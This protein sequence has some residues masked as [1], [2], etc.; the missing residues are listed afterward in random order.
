MDARYYNLATDGPPV[1]SS[2]DAV[3]L[4]AEASGQRAEIVV[5]PVER[6][7]DDF[8]RLSTGIAG[9]VIQKFLTYRL[10]VVILGDISM[11]LQD[12]SSL[13]DFVYECNSG[14]HV[15]FVSGM[16]ELNRRLQPQGN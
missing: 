11:H 8:F 7:S 10:R 14:S 12:S 5:I 9:E 13:R 1:R 2:R 16:E 6:L 3:D 4:I 15:W